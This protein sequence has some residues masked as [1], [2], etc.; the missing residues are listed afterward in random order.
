MRVPLQI[1]YGLFGKLGKVLHPDSSSPVLTDELGNPLKFARDEQG[2]P[3]A[4][5]GDLLFPEQTTDGHINTG[6]AGRLAAAANRAAVILVVG[7]FLAAGAFF[8]SQKQA[9][10]SELE[11]LVQRGCLVDTG[12]NRDYTLVGAADPLI[13]VIPKN[14]NR[15]REL[16]AVV[17]GESSVAFTGFSSLSDFIQNEAVYFV[18]R[19][20]E[21]PTST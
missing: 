7:S 14:L 3:L 8:W 2:R 9:A 17:M 10:A 13:D 16:I 19:V 18:P 4:I 15:G 11:A 21:F 20:I 6:Y 1:P 5:N 12:S